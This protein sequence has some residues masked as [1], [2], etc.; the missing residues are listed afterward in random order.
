MIQFVRGRL[1]FA[2]PGHIVIENNGI[3]YGMSVPENSAFFL[4]GEGEEALAYTSMMVR[5]DDI[6]L[7]GF[8]DRETQRMFHRLIGVSGIGAKAALSILSAMPLEE[9]VRA[10]LFEDAAS[11]TRANGIG[12]KSAQR[13]VL[14][15]KDK[16]EAA[17][18]LHAPQ[19]EKGAGTAADARGEA[20]DALLALGYS[21]SEAWS[22][23]SGIPEEGLSPE[24][25]IKR[26]LK[27][28]M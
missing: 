25:Y 2:G 5:E 1:A 4:L 3:G 18:G 10:I 20:A 11:L 27:R 23:L 16:V 7:Y 26:A 9:L 13:V 24:E 22:A 28:L 14:E 21:R 6:S 8:S 15:L 17:D 12:K 19:I